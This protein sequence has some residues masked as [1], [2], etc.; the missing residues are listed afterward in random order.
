MRFVDWFDGDRKDRNNIQAGDCGYGTLACVG[1]HSTSVLNRFCRALNGD[2][3]NQL[4]IKF[5][6]PDLVTPTLWST[7]LP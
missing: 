2:S 1:L 5:S 3:I 6:V 7:L 4:F